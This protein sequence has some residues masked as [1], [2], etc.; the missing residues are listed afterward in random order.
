MTAVP[1]ATVKLIGIYFLN[2]QI[3]RT[4]LDFFARFI[5]AWV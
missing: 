2:R 4:Q 3:L 5:Y 1:S